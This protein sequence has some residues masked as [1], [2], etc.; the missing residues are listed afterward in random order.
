MWCPPHSKPL[1]YAWQKPA[2]QGSVPTLDDDA[3]RTP[4]IQVYRKSSR[5]ADEQDA[6]AG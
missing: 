6:P 5:C 1:K 2:P 3:Q 4:R